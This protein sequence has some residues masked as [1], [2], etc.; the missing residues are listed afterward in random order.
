MAS[1]RGLETTGDRPDLEA[2][3]WF[4]TPEYSQTGMAP[5]VDF[6]ITGCYYPTATIYDAMSAG[7]PI[8][9][10]VEGAGQL[11][12]R[13]VRDQT[14]VYAGISLDQFK[15]NPDGLRAAMQGACGSTQGVMVF[16]LSHEIEPMWM[17]FAQAFAS[18]PRAAP[19]S[20]LT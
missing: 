17:V 4:L 3:F 14:W 2:G 16:D 8:G 20:F 12:N 15:G 1:I 19:H 18:D 7:L 9:F 11:S 13:I 5:L 10:S 6:M